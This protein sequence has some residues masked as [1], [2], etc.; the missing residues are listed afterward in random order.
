MS[1]SN[2]SRCGLPRVPEASFCGRCGQEYVPADTEIVPLAGA[3]ATTSK[4]TQARVVA[5]R[6]LRAYDGA[7]KN[8]WPRGRWAVHGVTA[9]VLLGLVGSIASPASPAGQ[10]ADAVPTTP[11]VAITDAT[12]TPTITATP[13]PTPI[14]E[15]TAA[16]TA[17]PDP[18]PTPAPTPMPE[19]TPAP[20]AQMDFAPIKKSGRG[21]KIMKFKIPEDAIG[22]ASLTHAGSGNF[23]VWAVDASGDET[24]LLVNDIGR[25]KGRVLFD[26]RDHSVAFKITASGSWTVTINPVQKI[27]KWNGSEPRKGSGDYVIRLTGT[28]AEG[29]GI[30]KLNHRGDGNFAIWAYGSSTDLLVNEIGRYSGEVLLGDAQVLE[31]TANGAW[32]LTLAD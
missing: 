32:T 13:T 4:T 19:P 6:G 16:P 31:I 26:E 5:G 22:M 14:P 8:R 2:C 9:L 18:T 27:P 11:A 23:A 10:T 29:F 3:A 28:A 20:T 30:L 1:Q 25:Y 17:T 24:D 15:A 21:D 7:L 12:P